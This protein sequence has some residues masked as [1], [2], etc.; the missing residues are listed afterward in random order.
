MK[1]KFNTLPP[2]GFHEFSPAGE[3][4]RHQWIDVIRTS[5]ERFG[6]YPLYTPLVEREENLL[7]KGGNPKEVYRLQRI[8][9]DAEDQSHSGMALRFDHTVPL[10]LYVARHLNEIAFPLRRYAIGPVF[11][12]ERAQK[13]RF[14]QFDQCDIDVIGFEKLSFEND[15]LM[16]AI[17]I[18]I[19]E[20]LKIGDFV[21]RINNRKL[22]LGLFEQVGVAPENIKTVLDIVD[23]KEKV[24]EDVFVSRLGEY[25]LTPESIKILT[26]FFAHTGEANQVLVAIKDTAGNDTFR[27]GVEEMTQVLDAL[28]AMNVPKNRYRLDLSI[29][30][31]LDYYTS[32]VYETRLIGHEYLGSICSG[33]R[34]D[35]LGYKFTGKPL[36]GVGISIGLT[37]LLPQ[38]I[39]AGMVQC[40]SVSPAR[41]LLIGVDDAGRA[42][43]LALG[44]E[45]RTQGIAV[46]NYV[47]AK[48]I[49]KQFEYAEKVGIAFCLI[50]G[51]QEVTDNTV[52]VRNMHTGESTT[53]PRTEVMG[54]L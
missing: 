16:P 30:R 17:I 29:A 39:E 2:S 47:E 3:R 26:D 27:E 19:F 12:G 38:L 21:V 6:F 50:L 45:L 31:G 25:G 48:K 40:P 34:Y 32:T 23:D 15:A 7:A 42:A 10:A 8:H 28:E 37:R 41:A 20:S 9:E 5:F 1:E 44:Q 35:D 24:P 49:Q 52:Q 13:G 14:R 51:A 46:E 36:P 54:H 22:L 33:G 11:R 53:V 18:E 4:L 43:A